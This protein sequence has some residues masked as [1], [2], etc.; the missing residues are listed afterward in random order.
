MTP[1]EYRAALDRLGITISGAARLFGVNP[2]TAQRWAEGKQDIP[3]AVVVCLDV[4]IR[5]GV[6]HRCYMPRKAPGGDDGAGP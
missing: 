6:D 3:R 1:V 5:H 2:R 4:M